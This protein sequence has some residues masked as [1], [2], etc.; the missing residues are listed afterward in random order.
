MS[1]KKLIKK[2][3]KENNRLLD[4]LIKQVL[5]NIRIKNMHHTEINKDTI[6]SYEVTNNR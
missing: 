6:F 2:L 4:L 3:T 1:K 5:E